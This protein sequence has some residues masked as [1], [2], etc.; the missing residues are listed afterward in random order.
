[1]KTLHQHVRNSQPARQR[2]GTQDW[3]DARTEARSNADG[4]HRHHQVRILL[5]SQPDM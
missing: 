2:I 3:P 4:N 1:M 5:H